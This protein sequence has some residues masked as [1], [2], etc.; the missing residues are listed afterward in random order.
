MW[1]SKKVTFNFSTLM[2][3][4]YFTQIVA[5]G[6][7]SY[8]LSSF[9]YGQTF[10][11]VVTTLNALSSIVFRFLFG[12]LM[13]KYSNPKILLSV[14]FTYFSAIQALL[15]LLYSSQI[16][17]LFYA[18]TGL[19]LFFTITGACDSW[20]LKCSKV[21]EK[22]D[23]AQIRSVG[24]IAY[25][26]IGLFASWAFTK[27][28][29]HA[30]FIIIGVAW[31]LF[32]YS[33]LVLPNPPKTIDNQETKITLREGIRYLVKNRFYMMSMVC[34]FLYSLTN[35]SYTHYYS[36]FINELGGTTKEIG[37]GLFVMAFTEFWVMRFYTPLAKKFGNERL[38]A[39]SFLCYVLRSF[40]M[41]CAKNT[42]QA[43]I[44]TALQTLTFAL[45]MPGIIATIGKVVKYEYQASGVQVM[46][47]VST[48]GQLIFG[49]LIGAVYENYGM[50]IMLR[51]FALPSLI[52]FIFFAI[53]SP[54]YKKK[55]Y[56][57]DQ[58]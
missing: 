22:I 1:N 15:F 28:G 47:L 9:G 16:Y 10:I 23:Y 8:F 3:G 55:G 11:G 2:T 46:G 37:L 53:M 58:G 7:L 25:A 33:V 6:Y 40:A 29:T 26:F 45:Q 21:D 30:A 41:S 51:I 54:L 57:T 48:A 13:D 5:L 34:V 24:S 49:T 4:F 36:L 50:V 56:Y 44:I 19:G 12:Y 31:L 18:V 17:V 35:V 39:F 27:F 43:L 38:L 32:M 52:A 14:S 20:V 42:T